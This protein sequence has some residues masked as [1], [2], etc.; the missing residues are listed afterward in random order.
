MKKKLLVRSLEKELED[1]DDPDISLSDDSRQQRQS[2]S[3]IRESLSL[4]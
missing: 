1:E 2:G 4:L 3:T